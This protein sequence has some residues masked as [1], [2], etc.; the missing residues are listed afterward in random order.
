ML[1]PLKGDELTYMTH[2][3][4]A[5]PVG[6]CITNDGGATRKRP[7][8]AQ[9]VDI[10]PYRVARCPGTGG[11]LHLGV[12]QRV[13]AAVAMN[14]SG[15]ATSALLELGYSKI[16]ITGDSAGNDLALGLPVYLAANSDTGGK[17]LVGL[18]AI[19]PVADLSRSGESWSIR[20]ET[21]PPFKKPQV[22]GL[23][24]P[25]WSRSVRS[26]ASPLFAD[27][28]RLAPIRIHVGDDEV[29]LADSV[30]FVKGGIAAGVDARLDVWKG[31]IHG[32]VG[33]VGRLAASN[34]A[35]EMIG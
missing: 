33:S 23:T 25:G 34:Q 13:L 24:E 11:A 15:L 30:Q 14:I 8:Q 9:L 2:S 26:C 20:A 35:L 6:S 4:K 29:L 1:R 27:S 10:H 32:F 3:E 19:S 16:A 31:M 28:R 22:A 12:E 7:R 21:D 17:A 18:V 5:T